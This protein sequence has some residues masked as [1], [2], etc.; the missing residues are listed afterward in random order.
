MKIDS[1]TSLAIKLKESVKSVTI[2]MYSKNRDVQYSETIVM[3]KALQRKIK[4]V[5]VYRKNGYIFPIFT[6]DLDLPAA[7][8]IEYYAARWKI[9]AGFKE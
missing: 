6:T 7:K 9:E 5:F 8:V 1:V 2:F 4:I 3:S